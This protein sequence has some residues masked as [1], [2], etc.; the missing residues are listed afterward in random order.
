MTRNHKKRL[1]SKEGKELLDMAA[2]DN[3][4]KRD[5]ALGEEKQLSGKK[6]KKVII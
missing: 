6:I 3:I 2:L 4:E 5:N 1:K